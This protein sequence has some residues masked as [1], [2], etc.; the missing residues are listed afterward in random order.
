M[1]INS[2][3]KGI[4][5][6]AMVEQALKTLKNERIGLISPIREFIH[7]ERH[8]RIDRAHIDF[9][10]FLENGEEIPL[11]VK[12]SV[13]GARKFARRNQRF[14]R[15]I[16]IVIV[17]TEEDLRT[18]IHKVVECI[19]STFNA[20]RRKVDWETHLKRIRHTKKSYYIRQFGTLSYH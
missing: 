20:L 8:S 13:R 15:F 2:D 6:E 7:A 12:S 3:S 1:N 17:N 16:P 9:V 10:V 19:R 11:Q 4:A 14:G 5:S 18:I